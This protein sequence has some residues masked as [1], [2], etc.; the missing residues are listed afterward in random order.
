[1]FAQLCTLTNFS[2]LT[3]ASHPQELVKTAQQLGYEAIAIT[4]ECSVAG[5]VRAFEAA[6]DSTIKLIIGSHFTLEDGLRLTLLAPTLKAYQELCALISQGR[7][8]AP[9]GQY[10]LER[11]HLQH[12][13]YC[14]VLWHPNEAD[15]AS[16]NWLKAHFQGRLWLALGRYLLPEEDIKLERLTAFAQAQQLP[17]VA[18]PKVRMH[19]PKRQRLLDCLSALRHHCTVQTAGWKLSANREAVL[20]P[21]DTLQQRYP[22]Q[23]LTESCRIANRCQ[24]SLTELHYRYPDEWLP[25]GLSASQYLAQEVNKGLARHYPQ[26]ASE[27]VKALITKELGLIAELGYEHYFLTLYDIVNFA[28][29][30]QILCQGRGSAANSAVCFCLGI[31]AVNPEQGNLLFERFISKERQEPPDIDV[32]FEHERREEV[33]QYIYRRY[34]RTRTALT[35]TVVSYRRKSAIRDIGKALGL[36]TAMIESLL[37]QLDGRDKLE[38]WREQLKRLCA[39]RGGLWPDFI[40]LVDEL[41]GFPRH[42][43]QHVGGFV[44][45]QGPLDQLVPQENASM[46]GRTVIQWDKDDLESL[47]LMKVDVLALGM[48]TAIRKCFALIK[49]HGGPSLTLAN[50]PQG[51]P[52]VYAMLQKADNVGVFQ[53]ESRAQSNMLPRLKPACFYDLVIEVAIVRPGPIQGDMVHPYLKRRDG[54]EAVSYPSSALEKVLKRTLG[55]P[56]FQEQVIEIAMVAANF[57]AGEADQLRRAMANWSRNGHI[58]AFRQ[59]LI[60]GMQDNGYEPAFA[61]RIFEQIKGFSGYG[62]PE[63]HSASFALLVYVSAWLKCHHRAAFCCALLNSQP[64]GFYTPSQLVQDA[65]RH[66]VEVLPVSASDSDYEHGLQDGRLRLGLCLIKGG[67]DAALRQFVMARHQHGLQQAL[68][69]LPRAQ[70]ELLASSGALDTLYQHR[71]QAAWQR[72]RLGEQLPLF[73]EQSEP[74]DITTA[75]AAPSAEQAMQADYQQLGLTLG[76]HPLALLRRQGRFSKTLSAADLSD[77][78]SGQAVH[79]AGLV[80]GRQRP[81]TASGVTFVTLE[82]ETGNINLVV[83]AATA[84]HQRQ[85]FLKARLLEVAGIVEKEGA[86]VHVMAGRLTDRSDWLDALPVPSRDFR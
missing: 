2:F 81:G 53:V 32:D 69:A 3:G 20:L 14:F 37:S 82:D 71:Y 41:I 24:F 1:M 65:K 86:I 46:A 77:C 45:S 51:D 58:E 57:S 23:W 21:L 39:N 31:T 15:T 73:A 22:K 28:R 72:A 25:A 27:K 60:K 35:A 79:V 47:G 49:H 34:G 44:I 50:V 76:R 68:A 6:K 48:L 55:V 62:F 26:G 54:L 63:S 75:L 17:V 29:Q 61:E 80:T 33:I 74:D 59:K 12:L 4:D 84:H 9:K 36:E 56:L 64:M 70:Q 52:A 5:V 42:L 7:S 16:A 18:A 30:Q 43:S 83:W 66:G 67:N 13:Q 10:R 38:P 85:A 11:N 78:V 40:E 8:Q 19:S